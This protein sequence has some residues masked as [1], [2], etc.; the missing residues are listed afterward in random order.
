MKF[1]LA[2][3]ASSA[4]SIAVESNAQIGIDCSGEWMYEACSD[5]YYQV[6]YCTYECGWWYAPEMDDDYSDDFWVTCDE[7]Y[8]WEQCQDV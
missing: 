6:D 5:M 2:I 7:W 3:L 4:A 1:A 8:S